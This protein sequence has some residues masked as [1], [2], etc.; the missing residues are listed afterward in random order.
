M[1]IIKNDAELEFYRHYFSQSSDVLILD[2]VQ[3]KL[4]FA[5]RGLKTLSEL[6]ERMNQSD[7]ALIIPIFDSH[8][9][10]SHLFVSTHKSSGRLFSNEEVKTLQRIIHEAQFYINSHVKVQ[11][12]SAL[13][14][15]IAHE[16]RNPLSQ[17]QS[18]LDLLKLYVLQNMDT[19]TILHGFDK[20]SDAIQRG[21]QLIDIILREIGDSSLQASVS[22]LHTDQLIRQSVEQFGFDDESYRQRIH[23]AADDGFP[24]KVNETLFN[25]VIFNLLRNALYY[26]S[27]YAESQVEIRTESG[28]K[29]NCII[30]RDTGPG[31]PDDVRTRIFEEFYSYDKPNGSGLGLSY[32]QRVMR[33]FGGSIQCNSEYGKFTEFRLHFPKVSPTASELSVLTDQIT[34][35]EPEMAPE[36]EMQPV[37]PDHLILVVDDMISQRVLL[38]TYLKQLGYRVIEAGNGRE[39]LVLF[40]SH[41]VELVIMDVQM[42]VMNGFDATRE[43]KALRASV[44][45][46]AFS[47]ESGKRETAL[48]K[49]IMDDQLSKPF[50]RSELQSVLAHW[51]S[52]GSRSLNTNEPLIA[53]EAI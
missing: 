47:G 36:A 38:V 13:A 2:E 35:S 15:S 5:K 51:L 45:V 31:I 37:S 3:E 30:F 23:I 52:P 8:N 26:F 42:P 10:I 25:F 4:E 32:C 12:Y 43:M 24:L 19:Q 50:H 40:Q 53:E 17:V 46:I 18:H 16:V 11:K 9:A 7:A 1:K 6:H 14:Y 21:N 39:A 34:V 27:S 44:P 48:I 49:E 28:Q 41:P 22:T 33:A 29:S 20:A